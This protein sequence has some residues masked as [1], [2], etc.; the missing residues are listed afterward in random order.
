MEVMIVNP[1][2]KYINQKK[3]IPNLSTSKRYAQFLKNA[4]SK[5][6]DI[7]LK[8]QE[9]DLYNLVKYAVTYVPYYRDIY[10]KLN[11]DLKQE[12]ISEDIKRFPI[13]TKDTISKNFGRLI[14]EEK[15][16]CTYINSSGGST[17]KPIEII[18]DREYRQKQ[19]DLTR[20]FDTFAGYHFGDK[21]ALVWGAERDILYPNS[22]QNFINAIITKL[23][24]N[25][26]TLNSF[27]MT[28]NDMF[29]Y[30][31]KINSFKPNYMLAYAQSAYELAKFVR[32]NKLNVRPFTGIITSAGTLYD[33]MRNTIEETF[34][35]KVFNR[36][37]SRETGLLAMECEAH[38][39]L[40]I[41]LFSQYIELLDDNNNVLPFNSEECGKVIVTQLNNHV[42][43][44]IRYEIGDIAQ[45]CALTACPCGRG[46][47]LLKSIRGRTVNV[48]KKKD[49]TKIDGEYFTHLF[50]HVNEIRRFQVIQHNYDD[51]EVI[52]ELHPEVFLEDSF[53]NNLTY[54]IQTIMGKS[55][56]VRYSLVE[57]IKPA[58][59]GKYIYTISKLK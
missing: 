47:P 42:M 43:P 30:V 6:L 32:A 8:T 57:K 25:T 31:Q 54:Q 35:C 24:R 44:L 18:Q 40:H 48:F 49:G 12:T 34:G 50:Y 21:L 11:F 58:Q 56:W 4:M 28:N 9:K 38:N 22:I 46:L 52:I 36:Y 23:Y 16:E 41:N 51:I 55:C 20:F 19:H 26:I 33:D 39:G 7:N 14:S 37:G 2:F 53:Y 17:G 1:I 13:L 15:F 45:R 3:F 59:S 27:M 5:P 29:N 10:Q